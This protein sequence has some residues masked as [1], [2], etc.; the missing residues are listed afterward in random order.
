[1]GVLDVIRPKL[2][3]WE[4]MDDPPPGESELA[5]I[6]FTKYLDLEKR[7]TR[8][9]DGKQR[10]FAKDLVNRGVSL[11][12]I[13]QWSSQWKWVERAEAYDVYLA[14]DC[15]ET[16]ALA[17]LKVYVEDL[18]T[19]AKMLRDKSTAFIEEYDIKTLDEA[20]KLQRLGI[21]IQREVDKTSKPDEEE[22][23][24]NILDSIR[25]SADYAFAAGLGVV[26]GGAIEGV[27]QATQGEGGRGQEGKVIE[28]ER[29]TVHPIP[30]ELAV[31]RGDN[32]G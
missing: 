20:V 28:G 25:R 13:T 8:T 10:R 29:R 6:A 17:E 14:T 18:R 24:R 9:A 31:V 26:V 16:A 22:Q 12:S 3:P 32:T 4:R 11:S 5:Y 15:A 19:T 27:R 21:D 1:M 23:K 7:G 2:R 30:R